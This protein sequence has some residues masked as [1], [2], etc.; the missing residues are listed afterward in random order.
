[1]TEARK[2]F[3][4]EYWGGRVFEITAPYEDECEE[5]IGVSTSEAV[6]GT[7]L[8]GFCTQDFCDVPNQPGDGKLINV[9]V[10]DP[11][12]LKNVKVVARGTLGDLSLPEHVLEAL[13]CSDD[14]RHDSEMIVFESLVGGRVYIKA[15]FTTLLE[16][17]ID[18]IH[19]ELLPESLRKA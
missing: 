7:Q 19:P 1:M 10:G 13:D 2:L 15:E 11:Y 14:I 8:N 3:G 5:L 6:L 12:L 4:L 16:N 18:R 9:V 17:V